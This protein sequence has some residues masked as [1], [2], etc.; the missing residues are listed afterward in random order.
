MLGGSLG[1]SSTAGDPSDSALLSP[2]RSDEAQLLGPPQFIKQIHSRMG[3]LKREV[4]EQIRLQWAFLENA[5]GQ[6]ASLGDLQALHAQVANKV[7]YQEFHDAVT[8]KVNSMEHVLRKKASLTDLEAL[9]AQVAK[10][11]SYEEFQDAISE[12]MSSVGFQSALSAEGKLYRSLDETQSFIDETQRSLDTLNAK[13]SADTQQNSYKHCNWIDDL[14]PQLVG[15]PGSRPHLGLIGASSASSS[16]ALEQKTCAHPKASPVYLQSLQ[17]KGASNVGQQQRLSG[18]QQQSLSGP[19]PQP[20]LSPP[21][22]KFEEVPVVDEKV[23]NKDFQEALSSFVSQKTF[24]NFTDATQRLFV[25]WTTVIGQKANLADLQTLQTQ[26]DEKASSADIQNALAASKTDFQKALSAV[27]KQDD[28]QNFVDETQR[29]FFLWTSVLG[30]KASTVDLQ[31]LQKIVAGKVNYQEFHEALNEKEIKLVSRN[32]P[33]NKVD[34]EGVAAASAVALSS[35]DSSSE[36]ASEKDSSFFTEECFSSRCI[37]TQRSSESTTAPS[38]ESITYATSDLARIGS[39][40]RSLL[41]SQECQHPPGL[42][43][44][45]HDEAAASFPMENNSNDDAAPAPHIRRL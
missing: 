16:N 19:T 43:N 5:L 18:G 24:Q 12:K 22:G 40:D 28:F 20:R 44:P 33:H 14:H 31:A 38:N 35:L 1:Q 39:P 10:K 29:G 2:N 15:Q 45:C 23:S 36:L 27:T 25:L 32:A 9:H 8:E 11:V 7:N 3:T 37:E 17:A 6:K 41:E 13:L 42:F 34:P 30:Q 26:L 4:N 21:P